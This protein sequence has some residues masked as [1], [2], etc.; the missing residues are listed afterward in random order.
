MTGRPAEVGPPSPPCRAAGGTQQCQRRR[1]GFLLVAW[2]LAE[3]R[4][5]AAAAQPEHSGPDAD[6]AL[7]TARLAVANHGADSDGFGGT[8]GQEGIA[9]TGAHERIP[10]SGLSHR[11]PFPGV[12]Q[13]RP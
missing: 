4:H 13:L 10:E 2:P 1:A 11:F 8:G 3:A 5:D 12:I 7:E 9:Q 6:D